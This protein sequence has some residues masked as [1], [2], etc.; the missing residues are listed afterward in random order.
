MD[1]L[2]DHHLQMLYLI[3]LERNGFSVILKE[4]MEEEEAARQE[5]V[6]MVHRFKMEK[7]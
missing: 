2:D 6:K 4:A 1:L 3:K 5:T 7:D